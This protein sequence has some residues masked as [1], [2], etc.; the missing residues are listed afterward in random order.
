MFTVSEINQL[1]SRD[2]NFNVF[3]RAFRVAAASEEIFQPVQSDDDFWAKFSAP[4]FV[5]G[6]PF[7]ESCLVGVRKDQEFDRPGL[8]LVKIPGG[9]PIGYEAAICE[10]DLLHFSD[11]V[12]SEKNINKHISEIS[13][14]YFGYMMKEHEGVW[15]YSSK[16]N[17]PCVYLKGVAAM[18]CGVEPG[19][20]GSFILRMLP[21]ILFLSKIKQNFDYLIVP[22]RTAWI[23]EAIEISGISSK[24][25]L[26]A[27]EAGG[28]RFKELWKFQDYYAE[29]RLSP[30]TADRFRAFSHS[31]CSRSA[32]DE[33][34]RVY[35]SR[36]LQSY[37]RPHYRFLQNQDEI[38]DFMQK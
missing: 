23:M 21:Q 31:C 30:Q 28:I 6:L 3:W 13:S 18:I 7:D 33:G 8:K 2:Q 27:K 20:F 16:Y 26:S 15:R 10:G 34:R 35:L 36:R 9:W 12:L 32:A 11:G 22:E 19:N 38:E 4:K 1:K 29:G 37:T 14:G 5:K 17:E 25:I 24:I